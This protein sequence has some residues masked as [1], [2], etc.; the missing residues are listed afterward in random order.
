[1]FP[2]RALRLPASLLLAATLAFPAPVGAQTVV[3][4]P[5]L[6]VAEVLEFPDRSAEVAIPIPVPEGLTPRSLSSTV[7]LPV[8]LDRGHLEAWSGDLLLARIDLQPDVES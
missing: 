5:A 7:Q 3:D 4:G 2:P 1:M 6:G 8:D